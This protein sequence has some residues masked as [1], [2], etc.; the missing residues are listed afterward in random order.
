MSIAQ[1]Q[2]NYAFID[3]INLHLTYEKLD[4]LLD[5]WKL[6]IYLA[7]KHNVTTAYYFLGFIER[8]KKIYQDLEAYGYKMKYRDI[9]RR[10]LDEEYC[11]YC[12]K[13]IAPERVGIKCDCDADITLQVMSDVNEYNKA[14]IITSDGDFDNLIK[15]LIKL[16]KLKLVLAPCRKGCSDLLIRAAFGRILFLDDL[17]NELE[18]T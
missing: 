3:G 13:C 12:W 11:P 14:V 15:G 6:R 4:W 16:D 9:S 17:K 7:K 1:Q 10:R 5:Y 8:N 2:G 18:K